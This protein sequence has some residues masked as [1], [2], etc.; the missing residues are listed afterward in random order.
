M[1]LALTRE[2][3][4]AIARCELTHLAREPI[5]VA[6]ACAQHRR[7]E[8]LLEAAG[9]TVLR[10]P[11]EPDLPDSVFVEDAA[12]VVDELAIVARPG[13]A[14]RR[15]EVT[16][17]ARALAPYRSLVPIEAPATIEGGDVLRVGRTVYVG[18]S[19]RTNAEGLDQLRAILAPLGYRVVGVPLAGCLH[20]KSAVTQ[21]AEET[22][23]LHPGWIDAAVFAA[24]E[25]IEI[26]P[27][28]AYAANGLLVR[29]TL[30]YPS[31]YRRTRDRL[32]A[33][34]IRIVEVDV[35][36]LAKAE[37]AVTCCSI[38]LKTV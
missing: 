16:T 21:V 24:Y 18:Q 6:R 1:D 30:V 23:L 31:A 7:Y 38:V 36:E 19:S 25:R 2:V 20:L 33:R 10:L 14:A 27:A 5:D 26:D 13:V 15:P 29:G 35:S 32:A 34:G 9:C 17:V 11:A 37:G 8:A 28:E 4:P 3:S 22:V 12:I